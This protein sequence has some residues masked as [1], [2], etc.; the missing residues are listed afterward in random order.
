MAKTPI[1][2]LA[3][4]AG[5]HLEYEVQMFLTARNKLFKSAPQRSPDP[6]EAFNRN[7]L[8]ES[9]VLH[10]RN[11]VD[12]FYPPS[13]TQPDDVT[14]ADYV[15]GWGSPSVPT[16]LK[17]ARTRANK[18]LAHLTLK[19]KAGAPPDKAWDFADLSNAMTSIIEDFITRVDVSNLPPPTKTV[20]QRIGGVVKVTGGAVFKTSSF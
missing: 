13:P 6:D 20:L 12:F 2:D 18:E 17:D 16:I 10:F 3:G 11:L 15:P 14:A 19:R 4:F 9:C 8:I 7:L 5:E 1:T